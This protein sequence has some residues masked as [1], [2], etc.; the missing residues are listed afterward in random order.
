M[1]SPEN[2]EKILRAYQGGKLTVRSV[3]PEGTIE[4]KPLLAA[5]RKETLNEPIVK[6]ST[7]SG[8]FTTTSDHSIY[9]TPT[10]VIPSGQLE[11]GME[12]LGISK[13]NTLSKSQVLDIEESLYRTFMYDV[14]VKDNHNLILYT[15]GVCVSNCP[16]KFYHFRPPTSS[17]TLNEFN[18]VFAYV[19]E[20]EELIEYM[21][22]AMFAINASPPETHFGSIDQMVAGK[23]D[24]IPWILTGAQVHACIALTLNWIAEEFSLAGEELTRVILPDGREIDV[25]MEELYEICK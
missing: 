9:T 22:Q 11:K 1:L 14:T 13:D 17:G 25:T 12:V 2:K 15:S 20:D 7:E 18:R 3:S 19:W 16:D 21:E 6:V 23:R 4:W 5:F 24:W 8:S 10:S